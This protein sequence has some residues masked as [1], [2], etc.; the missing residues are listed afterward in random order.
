MS[1]GV[2]TD[3]ELARICGLS[4]PARWRRGRAIQPVGDGRE[5]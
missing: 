5:G 2:E 4:A 3:L 1:G